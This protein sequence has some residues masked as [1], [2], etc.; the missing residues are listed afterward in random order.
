MLCWGPFQVDGLCAKMERMEFHFALALLSETSNVL[1]AVAT[2]LQTPEVDL[3]DCCTRIKLLRSSLETYREDKQFNTIY[4][5]AGVSKWRLHAFEKHL[6][7]VTFAG[8]MMLQNPNADV[9]VAYGNPET[10][11]H[12]RE[13]VYNAYLDELDSQ[14]EVRFSVHN[15]RIFKLSRLIPKFES[16]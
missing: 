4:T 12:F 8:F 9:P 2:A 3:V 6:L 1:K 11:K 16:K 14:L 10:K 5:A 7:E 13:S 15:E